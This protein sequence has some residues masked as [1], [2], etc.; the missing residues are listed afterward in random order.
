MLMRRLESLRGYFPPVVN[1]GVW[2]VMSSDSEFGT[3]VMLYEQYMDNAVYT[4]AED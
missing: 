1:R 4:A 2:D 3:Q